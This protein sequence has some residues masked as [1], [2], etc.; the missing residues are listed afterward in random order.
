MPSNDDDGA[1]GSCVP[2]TGIGADKTIVPPFPSSSSLSPPAAAASPT[3]EVWHSTTPACTTAPAAAP[4]CGGSSFARCGALAPSSSASSASLSPPAQ[5]GRAERFCQLGG[6]RF[7]SVER[8]T[9]LLTILTLPLPPPLGHAHQPAR[10]PGHL[11]HLMHPSQLVLRRS[12]H[13][14][15]QPARARTPPPPRQR[16]VRLGA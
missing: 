2:A 8:G 6:V 11:R 7:L 1:N 15:G 10:A 5:N 4:T 14:R 12:A 13:P 16:P 9:V 3:L